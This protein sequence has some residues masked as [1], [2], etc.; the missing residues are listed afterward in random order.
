MNII[1]ISG[2][3]RS[4]DSNT[5]NM[6]RAIIDGMGEFIA[7]RDLDIKFCTGCDKCFKTGKACVIVDD[8]PYQKIL[9]ADVIVLASPN[10]FK[11]VS[12]RMKNFFDRTNSLVSPRQLK[13]KKAILLA[14]GGQPVTNTMHCMSI[15]ED[16]CS[17]HGI[18]VIDNFIGRADKPN[19]LEDAHMNELAKIRNNLRSLLESL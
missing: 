8:M 12:G 19:S 1:G 5:D 7:L 3:H 10:Y 6:V 2:S 17:D 15:M 4:V 9:D 13:G 18:T 16:F 14:V 11:N